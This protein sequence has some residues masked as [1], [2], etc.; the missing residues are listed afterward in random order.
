[1]GGATATASRATDSVRGVVSERDDCVV[2][3][4]HAVLQVRPGESEAFER[5]FRE[6]TSIIAS[7]PG[8]VS[9]RLERCIEAPDRHLLLV[10][11][12]R[13]G[14]HTVGFRESAQYERWRDL[15]HHFYDP[16]PVV[17]HFEQVLAS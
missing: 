1:M 17:E 16:F 8:F 3:L 15:L 11:W 13:L 9:L 12:E 2:I 14:D 4:E 5:A 7:M 10:E 6:A